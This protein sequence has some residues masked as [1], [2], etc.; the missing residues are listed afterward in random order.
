MGAIYVNNTKGTYKYSRG[1]RDGS[2]KEVTA[3]IRSR[4][5]KR[6]QQAAA[7]REEARKTNA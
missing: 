1:M 2:C 7:K 3:V 6:Q 5:A 4:T